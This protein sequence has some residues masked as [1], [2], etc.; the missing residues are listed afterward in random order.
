MRLLLLNTNPAVS[1]LIKL[2]TDKVGYELDEFDDYGLV[3]LVQYDVILVDNEV[4]EEE[5]LEGVKETSE[6]NY[7]TFISEATGTPKTPRRKRSFGK[8]FYRPIF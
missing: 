6:C 3:P 5:A 2:S 4:Y 8:T 1:R 7:V